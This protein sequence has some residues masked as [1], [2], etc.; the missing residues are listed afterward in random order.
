MG[1][2][3]SVLRDPITTTGYSVA[4]TGTAGSTTAYQPG[5]TSVLV[6]STSDCYVKVGKALQQQQRILL[7]QVIR[8]SFYLYHKAL[9]H[10]GAY[11]Q[12]RSLQAALFIL[13][14]SLN[15]C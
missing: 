6:W 1:D 3:T 9:A 14:H 13:R 7:S 12:S 5:P 11:L 8:H 2:R 10:L 15:D 4:Y